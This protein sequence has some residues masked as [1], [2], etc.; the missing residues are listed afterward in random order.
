[1]H[2]KKPWNLDSWRPDVGY[3]KTVAKLCNPYTWQ[4]GVSMLSRKVIVALVVTVAGA[5]L[6]VGS[7]VWASAR[8]DALDGGAPGSST[9]IL[10]VAA[11]VAGLV[12]LTIG[13]ILLVQ[14]AAEP[15]S[16]GRVGGS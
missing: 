4:R 6:L 10:G 15:G 12:A 2:F 3:A 8:F 13:L 7:L 16:A 9:D 11:V 1:M 5:G 14:G